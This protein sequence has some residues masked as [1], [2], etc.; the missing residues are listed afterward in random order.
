MIRTSWRWCVF[1]ASSGPLRSPIPNFSTLKTAP[2]P[3]PRY[4][5][6]QYRPKVRVMKNFHIRLT[7]RETVDAMKRFSFG[8][9]ERRR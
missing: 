7:N 1:R 5:R 9:K 8:D 4:S 6:A 3:I 2:T